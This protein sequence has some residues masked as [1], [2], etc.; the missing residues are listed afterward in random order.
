M[1]CLCWLACVG[2]YLH[3]RVCVCVRAC[4]ACVCVWW[5]GS[6]VVYFR[7]CGV[8][9]LVSDLLPTVLHRTTL[10][11]RSTTSRPMAQTQGQA[12]CKFCLRPW[13][14]VLNARSAR[15]LSLSLALSASCLAGHAPCSCHVSCLCCCSVPSL[16]RESFISGAVGQCGAVLFGQSWGAG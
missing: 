8:W 11:D 7:K 5:T 1:V 15:S 16:L 2:A 6:V 10:M 14:D 3:A 4:A 13:R 12:P 9:F